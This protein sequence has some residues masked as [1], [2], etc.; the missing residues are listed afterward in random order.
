MLSY[1]ERARNSA[2]TT[3]CRLLTDRLLIQE[4]IRWYTLTGGGD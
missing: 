4:Q 1:H 2:D 3:A